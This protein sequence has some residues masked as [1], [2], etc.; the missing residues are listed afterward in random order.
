MSAPSPGSG[1]SRASARSLGGAVVEQWAAFV[2]STAGYVVVNVETARLLGLTGFGAF[3]S[4]VTAT[5]LI[6]QV[7]LLGTHRFGL[8]DTAARRHDREAVGALLGRS[9]LVAVTLV[10]A[11][12]LLTGVIA[13][14]VGGGGPLT[15]LVVGASTGGLVV[16]VANQRLWSSLLRGRGRHRPASLLDGPLGGPLALTTQAVVLGGLDLVAADV[17]L[18]TVLSVVV[19]A[20]LPWAVVAAYTAGRD[21]E[22]RL[23]PVRDV[24]D[25]VRRSWR[26]AWIQAVAYAGVSVELWIAAPFLSAGDLSL[27]SAA[28][29][30]SVALVAPLAAVQVVASPAIARAHGRCDT[31]TAQRVVKSAGTAALAACAPLLVVCLGWPGVVLDV[32]FGGGFA[33]GSSLL[34]W[35]ALGALVNVA[36]GLCTPLLA[37]T[38]HERVVATVLTGSLALRVSGGGVAVALGGVRA[39]VVIATVVVAGTWLQLY[40]AAGQR[41]GVSARPSLRPSAARELLQLAG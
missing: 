34:R 37:M 30:V 21:L 22:T 7:A 14:A 25:A 31:R 16:V 1:E 41:T 15:R 20:Q 27:L 26:F 19:L 5:S 18:P 35:L 29:R 2:V 10:P 11:A 24:I 4:I 32:L 28:N 23:P 40:V 6:G 17:S 9:R 39:L 12:G 33:A 3:V 8:R 13:A 38:G 36:T